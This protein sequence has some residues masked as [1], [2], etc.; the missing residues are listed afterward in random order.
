MELNHGPLKN[1]PSGRLK[2]FIIDVCAAYWVSVELSK[3][4]GTLPLP[5]L[6]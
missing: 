4:L 6:G 3:G 5:R 2:H 1:I